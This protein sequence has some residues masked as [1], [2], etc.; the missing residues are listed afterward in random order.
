MEHTEQNNDTI[1]I[2]NEMMNINPSIKELNIS[3]SSINEPFDIAIQMLKV[4]GSSSDDLIYITTKLFEAI[5]IV[6]KSMSKEDF[7]NIREEIVS[8]ISNHSSCY[9]NALNLKRTNVNPCKKYTCDNEYNDTFYKLCK[10]CGQFEIFHDICHKYIKN[11]LDR[12]NTTM[13][14]R[15]RCSCCGMDKYQHITCNDFQISPYTEPCCS[16]FLHMEQ[17]CIT[18]GKT[19]SDHVS[20]LKS[21]NISACGNYDIDDYGGCKNCIFGFS[22]HLSFANK[23]EDDWKKSDA[24]FRSLSNEVTKIIIYTDKINEMTDRMKN[25]CLNDNYP[26]DSSLSNSDTLCDMAV[27]LALKSLTKKLKNHLYET[28]TVNDVI[29]MEKYT[30]LRNSRDKLIEQQTSI[31]D[32]ISSDDIVTNC[33]YNT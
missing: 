21:Q 26:T 33:E 27:L 4:F 17:I 14:E 20:S 1:L 8:F 13:S 31:A 6:N 32:N 19:R 10:R 30:R 22:D 25:N 7:E 15:D 23:K 24:L 28:Y 29:T 12:K 11:N 18:C 5:Q 3:I 16:L 2:Y 9:T